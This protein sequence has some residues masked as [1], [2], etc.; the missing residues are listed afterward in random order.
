M[1]NQKLKTFL[2]S[3]EG[4]FC[5]TILYTIDIKNWGLPFI[6][7]IHPGCKVLFI[8]STVIK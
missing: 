8:Y 1:A 6:Y 3:K 7:F 4:I 2:N 5:D